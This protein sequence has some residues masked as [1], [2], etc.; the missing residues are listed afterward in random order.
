MDE[1]KRAGEILHEVA[2]LV[3]KDRRDTHGE[4]RQN[5]RLHGQLLKACLQSA[6]DLD[7][8]EIAVVTA[9]CGKLARYCVGDRTETDH[10]KDI[11]GYAALGAALIGEDGGYV[12]KSNIKYALKD[13]TAE[14]RLATTLE[15][16]ADVA[17]RGV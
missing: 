14:S 4:A 8:E 16:L 5:F 2:E 10:L 7:G 11:A 13:R 9:I 3:S 15:E 1:N 6:P 17:E 12:K